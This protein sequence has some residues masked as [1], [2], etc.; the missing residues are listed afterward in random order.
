[1]N[2]KSAVKLSILITYSY[3]PYLQYICRYIYIQYLFTYT[4][5]LLKTIYTYTTFKTM[6]HTFA[7]VYILYLYY[8]YRS[9]VPKNKM[10]RKNNYDNIVNNTM[11]DF[12][13]GTS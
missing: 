2:F 1:M 10:F 4:L 11:I 3:M 7:Y 5:L 6:Y 13:G 8:I 12:F 9:N